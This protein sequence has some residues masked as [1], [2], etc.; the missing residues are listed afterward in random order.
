MICLRATSGRLPQGPGLSS[1]ESG[2]IGKAFI[3]ASHRGQIH[4]DGNVGG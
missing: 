3:T 2:R 4:D 1:E